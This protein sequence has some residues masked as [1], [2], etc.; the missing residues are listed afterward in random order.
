MSEYSSGRYRLDKLSG[1]IISVLLLEVFL[2]GSGQFVSYNGMS[3]RMAFYS[4]ALTYFILYFF[5]G[6]KVRSEILWFSLVYALMLVFSSLIGFVNGA[7][8]N[9]IIQ[10]LKS[11]L[12]GFIILPLSILIRKEETVFLIVKLLRF[13]GLLLALSFLI[14]LA[15]MVFGFL[16]FDVFYQMAS[17]E[18]NDFMMN[19]GDIPRIF[20]KGFLYLG[21]GFIFFYFSKVKFRTVIM[22]V[23]LLAMILTFT[24][25][26]LLALILTFIALPLFEIRR[27]NSILM[28]AGVVLLVIFGFPFYVEFIG[29]KGISDSMRFLQIEQVIESV[30]PFSFI[31]GHG[32]GIG[33]PSR[34]IGMEITFLEIFHKQG[35]IGV[36]LWMGFIGYLIMMYLKLKTA[37]Y[38]FFAKPFLASVLYVFFQSLTNPYINNPIGMSVVLIAFVSLLIFSDKDREYANSYSCL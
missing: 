15:A 34:P 9:L 14:L 19:P 24:R 35:L 23:I 25:G 3:L 8:I 28:L 17:S 37:Q 16:N 11:L 27:K 29:D 36:L 10:N 2:L 30:T 26:F 38:K 33:V 32:F 18:A 12:Y 6:R 7:D 5:A 21:I 1:F 31:F 22:L 13:S 4:L 20:Y